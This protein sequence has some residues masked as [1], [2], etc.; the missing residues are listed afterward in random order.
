MW[1]CH[2]CRK[3]VAV[4]S[5][6]RRLHFP[7]Y[8][9]R[10]VHFAKH[11]RM[12][13]MFWV[14]K[15][16]GE[17]NPAD[18]GTVESCVSSYDTFPLVKQDSTH[19]YSYQMTQPQSHFEGRHNCRT[20]PWRCCALKPGNRNYCEPIQE[21]MPNLSSEND[22]YHIELP[23]FYKVTEL[24]HGTVVRSNHSIQTTLRGIH[25]LG[26]KPFMISTD[27]DHL[28]ST[29][30][31]STSLP[32][33]CTFLQLHDRAQNSPAQPSHFL[34]NTMETGNLDH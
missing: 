18:A 23:F 26:H 9:D 31:Y 5:I 8:V 14:F 12:W 33:H 10:C 32:Q 6:A 30:S 11:A 29:S 27:N 7:R 4:G 15:I 1:S 22:V 25:R 20:W 16:S 13:G 19:A 17:I 3:L 21:C 34:K 28:S 2:Q 24:D